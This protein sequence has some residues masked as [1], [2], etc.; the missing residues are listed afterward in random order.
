MKSCP[1]ALR[2]RPRPGDESRG[3]DYARAWNSFDVQ[4]VDIGRTHTL[5]IID[6]SVCQNARGG[7]SFPVTNA[8]SRSCIGGARRDLEL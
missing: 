1:S 6:T 5:V 2:H 3:D 4:A 7:P 8:G